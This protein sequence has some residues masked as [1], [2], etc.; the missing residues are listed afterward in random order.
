ML[1]REGTLG[2]TNSWKATSR[3][4]FSSTLRDRRE[5]QVAKSEW[6]PRG[7]LREGPSNNRDPG[8]WAESED[9]YLE[10]LPALLAAWPSHTGSLGLEVA[11]WRPITLCVLCVLCPTPTSTE[12]H[13]NPSR[14]PCQ[15]HYPGAPS[16]SPPVSN[17]HRKPE[18]SNMEASHHRRDQL[19]CVL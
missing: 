1:K 16:L 12:P 19:G 3:S 7:H 15:Y 8:Y 5:N 17:L 13:G 10:S 14:Q 9:P 6:M 18:K 4:H 11:S 2:N